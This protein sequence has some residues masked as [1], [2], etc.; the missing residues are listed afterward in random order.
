VCL[1][2]TPQ[3][4]LDILAWG[5]ERKTRLYLLDVS[6][7]DRRFFDL[8]SGFAGEL[9]QKCSNY[10]VRVVIVGEYAPLMSSRFGELVVELNRG[11][12]VRFAPTRSEAAE[13]LTRP[14]SGT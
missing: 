2:H 6:N 9:L 14:G 7:F 5:S 4:F 8:S 10:Q 11:T 3:D 12:L 13:W 1:V